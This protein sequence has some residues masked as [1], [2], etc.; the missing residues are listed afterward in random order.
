LREEL[1]VLDLLHDDQRL[2]LGA[3][4]RLVV[5]VEREEDDEPEQNREP[6]REHTEDPGRAVAVLKEA[7]GGRAAA[8]Q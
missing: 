7:A 8:H 6:G 1:R 2:L 5:T 4:S 3:A